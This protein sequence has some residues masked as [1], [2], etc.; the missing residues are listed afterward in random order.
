MDLS[1]AKILLEKVNSLYKSIRLDD[2]DLAAIER[3]LMLSYL[4]QLYALFRDE[5][6]MPPTRSR[7]STEDRDPTGEEPSAPP[8]GGSSEPVEKT[9][10]QPANRNYAP[11]RLIEIPESIKELSA[12]VA[13]ARE[14]GRKPVPEPKP[15]PVPEQPPRPRMDRSG[16]ETEVMQKLLEKPASKDLSEKLSRSPVQDLNRALAINDRLLYVD[17][18]FG[19]DRRAFESALDLLN[20]FSSF[21]E[22]ES[23]IAQLAQD[24]RWTEPG[25][26]P[27]AKA[28]VKLVQ[29]RYL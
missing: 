19:R 11:P 18:L 27:T 9:T 23:L 6:Q 16:E 4:R 7:P 20:G 21:E 1:K 17:Q 25:K 10:P 24:H 22:A 29:R 8:E 13:E 5:S 3:D 14:K 2:G 15:E 28:F 12:Q 26:L